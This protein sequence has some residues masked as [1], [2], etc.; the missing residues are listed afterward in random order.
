MPYLLIHVEP[1]PSLDE[2]FTRT[3][4]YYIVSARAPSSVLAS[5]W[6][7]EEWGGKGPCSALQLLRQL[8]RTTGETTAE[9]LIWLKA[10]D[11]SDCI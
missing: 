3:C 9:T 11:T 7:K 8:R 2:R 1:V 6:S 4:D 10:R 5:L